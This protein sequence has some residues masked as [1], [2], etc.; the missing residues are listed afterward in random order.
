MSEL[1]KITLKDGYLVEVNQGFCQGEVYVK[2]LRFVFV[3]G[4]KE[5]EKGVC[6]FVTLFNRNKGKFKKLTIEYEA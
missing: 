2:E 5:P 4:K 6:D 1:K 3:K